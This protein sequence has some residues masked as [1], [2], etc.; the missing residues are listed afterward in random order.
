LI[1]EYEPTFSIG[2][3]L[4]GTLVLKSVDTL[5]GSESVFVKRLREKASNLS[6]ND[7]TSEKHGAKQKH[8]TKNSI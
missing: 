2:L 8:F 3:D 7:V 4:G 5:A 1:S 6:E